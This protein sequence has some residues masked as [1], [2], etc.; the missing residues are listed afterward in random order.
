VEIRPITT[1]SQWEKLAQAFPE[2]TFLQSWSWGEFQEKLGDKVERFGV[3]EAGQCKGLFQVLQSPL[4]KFFK[5]WNFLHIPHG[6]LLESSGYE[7]FQVPSPKSQVDPNNQNL[8]FQKKELGEII[9]YV[10][11]LGQKEKAVFLRVEPLVKRDPG[12]AEIFSNLGFRKAPIHIHPDNSWLLDLGATETGL[13]KGMRKGHRYS[14]KKALN[15]GVQIKSQGRGAPLKEFYRLYQELARRVNFVPFSWKYMLLEFEVFAKKEQAKLYWATYKGKMVAA[16]LIIFY[17]ETAFYHHSA[18]SSEFS[19]LPATHLVLWKAIKEAKSQ[20]KKVFNFWGIAPPA[21]KAHP[22]KG[23][24]F[25][26]Q[27]FGGYRVDF[28]PAQDLS[29]DWKYWINYGIESL[30]RIK[31]SY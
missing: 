21:A 28:L 30:R 3:F 27:G 25:F 22:W 2:R 20:G 12:N 23:L 10:R 31:R 7:Q 18:S 16:S 17:G 15:Q 4:I 14:I 13:F 6:P 26:K 5:Q 19:H 24:T 9:R 29:L 8:N 1:E 11:K